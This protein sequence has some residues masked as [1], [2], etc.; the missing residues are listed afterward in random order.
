MKTT[1]RLF[2]VTLLLTLGWQA[3]AFGVENMLTN[4]G[5][6]DLDLDTNLGDGWGSYGAAGFNDFFGGDAHASL[7]ADTAGNSGGIY[8][9]GIA[10]APGVTYQFAL[11]NVRI[12]ANWDADL[13]FGLEYYAA[14]DSTK[15]GETLVALDTATRIANSQ[16]EGNAFAM[17]GTAVAGTAYVRPIIYFD[18]VNPG[19]SG[20]SQANTFIFDTFL[21]VAAA[22]GSQM[23]MNP[24][25]D[26]LNADTFFG[27]TWDKYGATDFN[28]F[29][30]G[31]PHV[32]FFADLTGNSGGV[33]QQALLGTPDAAYRFTL[34]NVR[35]EVLFPGILYYGLEFYGADDFVKLG[36]TIAQ[37]PTGL[38]GDG[39]SFDMVGVAPAGTV[40]VRP[41]IRFDDVT[42]D[43]FSDCNVFVFT[44]TLTEA[45]PGVNLLNNPSF[46]DAN[47]DTDFGDGWGSYWNTGFNEFF[48]PGNAHASFY[49]DWN[50]NSGGVFQ[51]GIPH[52]PG[53]T[54][55]FDI[56]N[57]RIEA[58]WDADFYFGLE[59]YD[60]DDA[61]KLGETLVLVDT[62]ARLANGQ[63]DGNTF[64]MQATPVSG[65]VFV[66]PIMYFDN[67][68]PTYVAM[69]QANIFVFDAF[70]GIAP[71]PAD[72]HVK[73]PGF[74]DLDGNGSYGDYWGSY[75]AAG[76]NEF[77]GPNNAHASLFADT[78][79]NLGGVYQPSVLGTPGTEYRFD[80]LDVR[81]EANWDADLMFGLEFYGDDNFT[82]FGEIIET[83]D[84]STTGDGL[85]FYMTGTAVPG[86]VYVR[87]V[88]FYDNVGTTGGSDR[89]AFVF[90]V[91]LTEVPAPPLG[92]MNC[93]S[94]LDITDV[95]PFV[96]A[97]IDPAQYA[98]DFAGC[99]IANADV[100]EDGDTNGLDVGVFVDL[101]L[102][103]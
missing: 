50:G 66:R 14:D 34:N 96:L 27:D 19:Y 10:G 13:V 91:S 1:I 73:N 17:Q 98:I 44:A 21:C 68:N 67:V 40:Y 72:I 18:N 33:F 75:G 6:D 37:A 24:G 80:L 100:N 101:L 35:I 45:A 2:A 94:T 16:F 79:G 77:F 99:D 85:S 102:A 32:S 3:T 43:A 41:I 93:D 65:T 70:L 59:Y 20:Q 25:F 46:N 63:I 69:T 9:Q 7:F 74:A 84:T 54:Y 83:I 11:L 36:E 12:E 23:L 61:T 48:G 81:I 38:T 82:K 15:L 103:K 88:V 52:I 78:I 42:Y 62:G 8:Q 57:A 39:L 87:P 64:S 58:N 22:P 76:F 26:D 89:N 31:N 97:L 29:W 56:L 51:L 71:G 28:D 86:T 4:P 30:V 47:G 5:F 53:A 90:A 95:E 49:G 55:Q 92:D 60:A